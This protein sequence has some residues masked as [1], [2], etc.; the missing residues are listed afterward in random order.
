MNRFDAMTTLLAVADAGSLSAASRKIGVPLATISR[1]ISDLEAHLGTRLF[2]RTN[3]R[4]EFSEGGR[5]FVAAC[6]D[7]AAAVEQAERAAAGEASAPKGEITVTAPLVFGRLHALP[8][9]TEFLAAYPDI[10]VRLH[11]TDRVAHFIEDHV[12]AAIRIGALPDSSLIATRL[13][14]V[15][16]ICCASPAYLAA[17][18]APAQPADLR[19]HACISFEG[20]GVPG[21]WRFRGA[22]QDITVPITPR[23][24][25]TTAEAAIDAAIAGTGITKVLSYQAEAALRAGSLV[26]LLME[27]E[28]A[29]WPVHLL[30][31]GQGLL[32]PK[33]RAFLSFATPKLRQRIGEA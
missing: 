14:E 24:A 31:S 23:L 32:P 25:V 5:A 12:D 21:I 1:R 33:T 28:P 8:V 30:H 7:I 9:V 19:R 16:P 4:P 22:R 20:L 29:P 6:R 27:F 3:R 2:L 26:P 17:H 18:G 13:G 10:T 11:L 15:R